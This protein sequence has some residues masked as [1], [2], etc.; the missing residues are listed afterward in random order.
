MAQSLSEKIAADFKNAL[1]QKDTV[2]IGTLRLLNAAVI[3]QEK[4]KRYKLSRQNLP[5]S[6]LIKQSKLTDEELLL[7]I[8]SEAKKRKEAILAFEKGGRQDL[9]SRE[10]EELAVLERYLPAQLSDQELRQIVTMAI[11]EV[12]AKEPK[13]MGKVMAKI[14]PQVKGQADG[15]RVSGLVRHLLTR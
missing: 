6:E 4:E 10:K 5:E 15:Q 3:S 7:V 14:M 1:A 9:V 2:A 13:D 11:K 12:G 8:G